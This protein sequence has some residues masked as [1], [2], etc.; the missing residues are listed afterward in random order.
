MRKI[1]APDLEL[2]LWAVAVLQAKLLEVNTSQTTSR[3]A[4]KRQTLRPKSIPVLLVDHGWR[5]AWQC[6]MLHVRVQ[7]RQTSAGALM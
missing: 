1:L 2:P 6:Q 7:S 5:R 3:A 4:V